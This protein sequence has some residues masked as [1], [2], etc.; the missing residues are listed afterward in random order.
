MANIL[1]ML[2]KLIEIKQQLCKSLDSLDTTIKY[3]QTKGIARHS[4][5]G[6][7]NFYTSRVCFRTL[8]V[9][10]MTSIITV[11]EWIFLVKCIYLL[12]CVV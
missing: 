4:V 6:H 5:C 11:S 1:L 10:S 12:K 9:I 8:L 2:F 3:C 7:L